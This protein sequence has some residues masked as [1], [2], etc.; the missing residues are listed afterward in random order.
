MLKARPMS[1]NT[2]LWR[3]QMST[4]QTLTYELED[5]IVSLGMLTIDLCR[6]FGIPLAEED[7]LMHYFLT[8]LHQNRY[9][10]PNFTHVNRLV[11]LLYNSL[12]DAHIRQRAMYL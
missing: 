10:D 12:Q 7:K 8:S 3:A 6:R 2:A 9:H 5:E 4:T 11:V 1:A